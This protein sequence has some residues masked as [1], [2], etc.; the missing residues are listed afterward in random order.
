MYVTLPLLFPCMYMCDVDIKTY[1]GVAK[2]Y[3]GCDKFQ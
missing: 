3:T 1:V 2:K